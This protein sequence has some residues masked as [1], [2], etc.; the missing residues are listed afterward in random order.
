MPPVQVSVFAPNSF[1]AH[2]FGFNEANNTSTSQHSYNSSHPIVN[3]LN[4]IN[5]GRGSMVSINSLSSI[6]TT[7]GVSKPSTL[8]P[9]TTTLL[10]YLQDM[11]PPENLIPKDKT[12]E[13]KEPKKVNFLFYFYF[14]FMFTKES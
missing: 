2:S 10:P 3:N 12:K 1:S 7:N 5:S 8:L 13:S 9:P 6:Q 14:S 11:F 4:P